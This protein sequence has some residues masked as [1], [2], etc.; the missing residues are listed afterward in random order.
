M[1]V[2]KDR[3]RKPGCSCSSATRSLLSAYKEL[4]DVSFPRANITTVTFQKLNLRYV[5]FLKQ[6]QQ[7]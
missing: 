7:S 5:V 6:H 4:V 3:M 2:M 1:H